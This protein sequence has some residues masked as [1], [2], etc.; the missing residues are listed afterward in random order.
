MRAETWIKLRA[1]PE[2]IEESPKDVLAHLVEN[3]NNLRESV[4]EK[5]VDL[6]TKMW[7]GLANTGKDYTDVGKKQ[8]YRQLTQIH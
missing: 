8:Q 6:Y 4:E 1:K 7:Q 3:S 2:E 5:A